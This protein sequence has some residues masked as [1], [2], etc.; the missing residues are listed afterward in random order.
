MFNMLCAVIIYIGPNLLK[1]LFSHLP[2][3]TMYANSV[4]CV[5]FALKSPISYFGTH[6]FTIAT[7]KVKL[8]TRVFALMN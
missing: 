8:F 2:V 7:V 4:N 5:I 1:C 3:L 6:F